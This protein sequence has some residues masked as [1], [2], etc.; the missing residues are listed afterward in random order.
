M[1]PPKPPKPPKH[2]VKVVHHEDLPQETLPDIS[3][4][5]WVNGYHCPPPMILD[6]KIYYHE[7][8]PE[9]PYYSAAGQHGMF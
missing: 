3:I 2:S 5:D 8:L 1:Q 9:A 7:I 4:M 6:N